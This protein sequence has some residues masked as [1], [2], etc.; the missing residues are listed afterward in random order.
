M[1]RMGQEQPLV[2]PEARKPVKYKRQGGGWVTVMFILLAF[3]GSVGL[4]TVFFKQA[5]LVGRA[6]RLLNGT[7]GKEPYKPVVYKALEED[8]A[9]WITVEV[10]PKK[11]RLLLDGG[12]IASNPVR[13][14]PGSHRITAL[15]D[16]HESE[17]EEFTADKAR[18]IRFNLKKE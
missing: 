4:A 14:S 15:A 10:T 8:G 16:G 5:D 17:A 3:V 2:I 13:V 6:T 7:K 12:P 9:V 18:T 1:P 11:A